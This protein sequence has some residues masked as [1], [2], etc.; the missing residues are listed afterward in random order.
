MVVTT[1]KT[2]GQFVEI[3]IHRIVGM[4]TPTKDA[5]E[6]EQTEEIETCLVAMDLSIDKTEIELIESK[7]DRTTM[8]I[9]TTIRIMITTTSKR[10]FDKLVE[11]RRALGQFEG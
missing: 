10:N 5:I 8:I 4:K 11:F 7:G 9:T 6:I 3:E 1:T 2:I